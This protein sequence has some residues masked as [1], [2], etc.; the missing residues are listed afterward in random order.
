MIFML[1]A[2]ATSMCCSV[3]YIWQELQPAMTLV[4]QAQAVVRQFSLPVRNARLQR[5]QRLR[6][7]VIHDFGACHASS[8]EICFS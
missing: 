8:N 6:Q 7:R 4:I 3:A 5:L 1:F 2:I